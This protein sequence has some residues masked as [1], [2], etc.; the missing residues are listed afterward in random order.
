M[1]VRPPRATLPLA[2]A[3]FGLLTLLPAGPA[4]AESP[5]EIYDAATKAHHH[6][7][8]ALRRARQANSPKAQFTEN[9][10]AIG[11][12]E[13]AQRLLEKY[14]GERPED[15]QAE[16]LM[17]DVLS[18]LFWCHKMSPM[19]DPE[20]LSDEPEPEEP[21]EPEEPVDSGPTAEEE[22]AAKKAER[23]AAKQKAAEQTAAEAQ[24][25]L[26]GARKFLAENPEDGMGA[27]AK[28]FYVAERFPDSEPGKAAKDE[29]AA[30]QEKLF[31]VKVVVPAKRK[32]VPLTASDKSEI[33]KTL[34]GWL[35]N[36][37]K[38]R[39]ASCKGVGESICKK[40]DGSGK[41]A[42]RAGRSSTC[43]RCKRGKIECKRRTCT[44]GID[45][46]FL[47]KVV[48]DSRAPYYQDKVVSLLGGRSDA[49][50]KFLEALAATLSGSSGVSSV[51]TRCAT[52]L[53]IEPVQLRDVLEA[54]GPSE[55]IVTS[56]KAYSIGEI[57]RKATY[58]LK[59]DADFDETATFEQQD[60]QWYVRRIK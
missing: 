53:G 20:E 28:F 51:I 41:I 14:L 31:A 50:E 24:G 39:C 18:L 30:L 45:T 21:E 11:H 29:A 46:R 42:G 17:Q 3:L 6:G 37:Q 1:I 15:G 4:L 2:V 47:E 34:K 35:S 57:D 33:E 19:V 43:P 58:T 10:N 12:L 9:E 25:L 48:I 40:C 8:Q 55:S 32:K 38:V 13:Q 56:F 44:K 7:N 54:H 22:A 52:D 23:A 16:R 5:E 59:G 26:E 49:L 27:L 60:G 36:R